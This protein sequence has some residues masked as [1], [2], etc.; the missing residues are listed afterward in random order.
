MFYVYSS[1]LIACFCCTV[2][3]SANTER[4]CDYDDYLRVAECYSDWGYDFTVVP[5]PGAVIW[6]MTTLV[7]FCR[8]PS[9]RQVSGCLKDA[10]SRCQF[11]EWEEEN[12]AL[13]RLSDM[14]DVAL[15]FIC[16]KADVIE[17][18]KACI[19]SD[20][21]SVNKCILDASNEAEGR[22]MELAL[23]GE[24]M[25]W[26]EVKSIKQRQAITLTK[27]VRNVLKNCDQEVAMV[28]SNF[29][30]AGYTVYGDD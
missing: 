1:L 30:Y 23:S 26:A 10:F 17:E 20:D 22:F 24:Q 16:S 6:N 21:Y 2:P 11:S 8:T 25:A 5:H 29:F 28:F 7:E 12:E 19:E 3:A 4:L 9:R 27:C 15:K 13:L 18:N 14:S